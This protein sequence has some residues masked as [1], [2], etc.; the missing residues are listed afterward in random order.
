[1]ASNTDPTAAA[2]RYLLVALLQRL[3]RDRP[4]LTQALRAGVQ[5]DRAATGPGQAHVDA[6]FDEALRMLDLAAQA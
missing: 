3:E 1:M 4:G 6:T 5:A 2:C